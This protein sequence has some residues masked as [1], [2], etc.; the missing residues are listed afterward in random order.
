M[1]AA[2]RK[3][4][5]NWTVHIECNDCGTRLMVASVN[6]SL[7]RLENGTRMLLLTVPN[8]CPDCHNLRVLKGDGGGK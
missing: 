6:P 5:V 7:E 3:I 4:P 1:A 8:E 2:F